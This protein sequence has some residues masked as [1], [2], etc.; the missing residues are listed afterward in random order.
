M[1]LATKFLSGLAAIAVSGSA[2][3]LSGL[4]PAIGA[5]H[6][7]PPTRTDPNTTA[8]PD[9]AADL[10]DLYLFPVGTTDTHVSVTFG[11]PSVTSLGALMDPDVDFYL[12]ISNAGSPTDAE[13]TIN[14]RFGRDPANPNALGVRITGVPGN[15]NPIIM[16]VESIQTR[17]GVKI[18]A[19]L[20]DDPFNFDVRACARPGKPRS[21]RSAMTAT[22]S[23]CRT[24]RSSP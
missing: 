5:D 8:T 11:G 23:G 7:D 22:G 10:A 14:W 13:I 1:R 15:P 18:F 17:N 6:F 16:P 9:V 19:G 12:F 3:W 24:A 2:L 20:I 4:A 21:C